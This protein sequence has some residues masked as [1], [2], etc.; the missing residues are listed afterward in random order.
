MQ[1][2]IFVIGL[3]T[4]TVKS[5]VESL[6]TSESDPSWWRWTYLI[7]THIILLHIHSKYVDFIIQDIFLELS[8]FN[9]VILKSNL[10]NSIAHLAQSTARCR[11]QIIY[12]NN[13]KIVFDVT[14]PLRVTR[15]IHHTFSR[16]F[17]ETFRISKNEDF[18]SPYLEN[19]NEFFQ[20]SFETVFSASKSRDKVQL[21]SAFQL[22]FN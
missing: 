4:F 3:G 8:L 14:A 16:P 7:G 13:P 20:N 5:F 18:N 12:E 15:G 6:S 11:W 21:V 22:T 17:S 2:V 10:K 19:E 1:P 9:E